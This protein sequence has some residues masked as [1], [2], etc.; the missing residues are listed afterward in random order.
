M[1]AD[2]ITEAHAFAV[3][4]A[5]EAGGV[6]RE[7]FDGPRDIDHKGTIDIVTD[8]DRASETLIANAIRERFPDHR[9]LA[10]EGATAAADDASPYRWVV[11]P[12]DG[13][14]NFAHRFPHFAVCIG[15]ERDGELLA[16]AVYDPM[17]DEMFEAAKGHGARLNGSPIRVSDRTELISSLLAS[18]FPYDIEA[19]GLSNRLWTRFNDSSQ[20]VR[21]A[22]AAALD[23]VYVACGRVDGYWERPVMPWDKAASCLIAMEA[24]ARVTGLAGEPFDVDDIG[25]TVANPALHALMVAEI[26]DE[27]ARG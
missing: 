26:N 27:M 16:G 25:A 10:E 7:R 17:R 24:G 22:G 18:G 4:L 2:L 5:R 3:E 20:G 12:L 11:D 1:D 21:R 14:T 8:A 23:I 9:L 13:T 15:L 6:L 19:R